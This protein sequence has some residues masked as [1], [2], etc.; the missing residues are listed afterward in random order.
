MRTEHFRI[1]FN[2]GIGFSLPNGI[3]P[4]LVVGKIIVSV[5]IDNH[6][7]EFPVNDVGRGFPSLYSVGHQ[8]ST[9]KQVISGCSESLDSP[10]GGILPQAFHAVVLH[11]CLEALFGH[12]L[13]HFFANHLC[14]GFRGGFGKNIDSFESTV[15]NAKVKHECRHVAGHHTGSVPKAGV[16]AIH[17][18]RLS[19][20]VECAH[21]FIVG[22]TF[23]L[24]GILTFQ[25]IGVHH[26][27]CVT[28][29]A[30]AEIPSAE[31]SCHTTETTPKAN[32]DALLT[33]FLLFKVF[34]KFLRL[35]NGDIQGTVFLVAH[36]TR[37]IGICCK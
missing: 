28:H 37:N 25:V 27:Q 7:T 36:L 19:F 31:I 15:C 34:D 23:S 9:E 18:L 33:V 17:L 20:V 30:H 1:V 11:V 24:C 35:T 16:P 8:R 12:L 6:I 2:D 26:G 32:I 4:S 13:Y 14:G 5:L 10:V 21:H 29:I 3:S 22:F